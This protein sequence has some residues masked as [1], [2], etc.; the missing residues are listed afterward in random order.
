[1]LKTHA[2]F[3]GKKN[4]VA[5]DTE[6]VIEILLKKKILLKTPVLSL[7]RKKKEMLSCTVK[8]PGMARMSRVIIFRDKF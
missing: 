8:A 7:L 2:R 6:K 1:M 4:I 5:T 3:Q